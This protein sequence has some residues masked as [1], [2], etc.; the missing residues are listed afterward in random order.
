MRHGN[1][2]ASQCANIKKYAQWF[3]ASQIKRLGGAKVR[4]RCLHNANLNWPTTG[5]PRR[6]PRLVTLDWFGNR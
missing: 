6:G 3:R 5:L 4:C 1:V 2:D